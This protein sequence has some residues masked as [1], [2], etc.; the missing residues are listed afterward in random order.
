M[1]GLGSTASAVG[2]VS[3]VAIACGVLPVE[4]ALELDDLDLHAVHL[5]NNFGAPVVTELGKTVR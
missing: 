3:E 2:S 4:F 5:S 1:R